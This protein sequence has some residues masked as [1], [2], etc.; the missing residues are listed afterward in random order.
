LKREGKKPIRIV[1]DQRRRMSSKKTDKAEKTNQAEKTNKAE[2]QGR[3][4]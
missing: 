1:I 3:R 4:G 2:L